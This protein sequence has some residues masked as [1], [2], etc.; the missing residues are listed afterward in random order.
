MNYCSNFQNYFDYISECLEKFQTIQTTQEVTTGMETMQP[1]STSGP[2][3]TDPW[4][5]NQPSTVS[6]TLEQT[7]MA[8]KTSMA[9]KPA[10]GT[11]TVS[12][13][14]TVV[15]DMELPVTWAYQEG[16]AESP[17]TTDGM[18]EFTTATIVPQKSDFNFLPA[19]LITVFGWLIIGAIVLILYKYKR[20]YRI[21]QPSPDI[22]IDYVPLKRRMTKTSRKDRDRIVEESVIPP[23]KDMIH[24]V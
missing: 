19:V 13:T 18:A 14:V 6:S 4:T 20:K 15:T 9:T 11:S 23:G 21:R 3:I 24:V 16:S 22:E 7:T 1:A 8:T 5:T 12:T 2:V 17:A 10:T